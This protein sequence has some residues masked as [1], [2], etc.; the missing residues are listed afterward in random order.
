MCGS[1]ELGA[2]AILAYCSAELARV[3]RAVKVLSYDTM[4]GARLGIITLSARYR[5]TYNLYIR[6]GK[7]AH[8]LID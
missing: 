6:G 1:K 5:Q 4:E 7:V 8:E 2:A 3:K